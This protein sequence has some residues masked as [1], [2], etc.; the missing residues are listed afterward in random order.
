MPYEFVEWDEEP[1][2]QAGSRRVGGPPRKSTGIG[3]LDPPVPPS[4]H[5]LPFVSLPGF[6]NRV[7]AAL[8]LAALTV[9]I[10]GLVHFW[11]FPQP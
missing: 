6:T 4:K 8:I 1:E 7:V 3:V 9:A 11:F 10:G 2:T 5:G